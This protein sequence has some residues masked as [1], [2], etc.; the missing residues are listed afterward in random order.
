MLVLR[1]TIAH[2]S[3]D[4]R[5]I[6]KKWQ[7]KWDHNRAHE[8]AEDASRQKEKMYVLDMFPYPSAQGL[9]VGH[10]EGY[11]A[12]DIVSRYFRMRG[13]HVLH[14]M[15]WDAFGLPAENYA[16][17]TKV[18]PNALTQKNIA[19]FKRQIQSLGFSYDWSREVDTSS[20]AYY[21]WTQWLFLQLYKKGLAYKKKAPVNW[22]PSCQTVLANEQVVDGA[23]ERC[24]TAV[25]QKELEQWFFKITDYVER[26]LTDLDALD[27]PERIKEMQRNWIGKSQGVDI[28]S[29][30]KDLDIEFTAYDS[31][32]QTFM[33][34]TFTVI[35]P[36]HPMVARLVEGTTYEKSVMAWV[37]KIKKKKAAEKFSLEKDVDGIFTGRYVD[38]PFG[39]GDLPIWI[40]SFAVMGYGSGIVH[41]SAHDARDFAFAKKYGIPLRPVMFPKDTVAAEKVRNLEVCFYKDPEGILEAPL[42]LKG[43]RWGDARERIIAHL[44]KKGFAKRAT[45]YK[46]RDWLVSRQRYWGAPIPIIYCDAC[47]AVPV[48]EKDLPVELPTDVDFQPTGESPLARSKSFHDVKCPTCG[49]NARRE[50]DTMDTFV[51]SSWYF[52][53]YCDPKNEKELVDKKKVAYWS[54]VDLYVGGAEHA[55][56]HLLYARFITKVLADFGYINFQEPFLKLRNQGMILGE[57]GQKMSKSRGNV[58]N[59]DE[60]VEQ[61]GA[62]TMRLYE[63]FMG[64]FEDT[65]PWS[66]DG[67]KG[68]RR[69]LEKVDR[70]F[71]GEFPISNFQFPID[72]LLHKTIKKVTEDIESFKFN[73]AISAMMIFVNEAQEKG[74]TKEQSEVFLRVLAPFAPHLA[75]E[76]WEKL[77]NVGSIFKESWPT[78]DPK[79]VQDEEIELVVQVNGKLRDRFTVSASLIEDELKQQALAREKVK[80]WLVGK[81]IERV[82][83]VKGRL[84]NIVVS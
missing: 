48:P 45:H 22:C 47:G 51:D 60:V 26:L 17:K 20:P 80:A 59:P 11:T 74:L 40:A 6:E 46:I 83:V 29:R 3:Y 12:T 70:L 49:K 56:L 41:C 54:P 37:E 24:H 2:M 27:W 84:V 81:K 69:L 57:D 28:F 72:R 55:V 25:E 31:V 63:M 50:S 4:H 82:V 34:Q 5:T 68:V 14:P 19:T 8:V 9:H 73:T 79:L 16:I 64:P 42:E 18:H 77:G 67:I 38:N 43:V 32:P 7:D 52:L 10:P 58:I 75:E 13:K 78:F 65:K 71:Q 23:C 1:D 30:V 62:D 76:L 44:E 35:A 39:T 61:Y 33:A 36:E 53:R 21:R 66:T 15:G